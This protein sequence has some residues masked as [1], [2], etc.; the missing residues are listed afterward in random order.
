[1]TAPSWCTHE[2]AFPTQYTLLNTEAQRVLEMW[3]FQYMVHN[4]TVYVS[5]GS[6]TFD[7]LLAA[8]YSSGYQTMYYRDN[9]AK[10]GSSGKYPDSPWAEYKA[11]RDDD[12]DD[13]Y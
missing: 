13:E 12:E 2:I 8:L 7:Q 6:V 3:R 10:T 11:Y 9:P 5:G 1:M 4:N